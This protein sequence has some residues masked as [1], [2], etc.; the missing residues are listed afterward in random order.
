MEQPLIHEHIGYSPK[1]K[2]LW[3]LSVMFEAMVTEEIVGDAGL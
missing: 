3:D 1:L 2:S